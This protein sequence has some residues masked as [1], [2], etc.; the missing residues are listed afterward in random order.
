MQL[1]DKHK[2]AGGEG[3]WKRIG[4]ISDTDKRVPVSEEPVT[5]MSV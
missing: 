4:G 1:S 5:T 3:E 2:V